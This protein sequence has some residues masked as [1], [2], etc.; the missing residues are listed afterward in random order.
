MKIEALTSFCG[1]LSMARGEVRD[2]NNEAVIADLLSAG[3]IKTVDEQT[4]SAEK[5]SKAST[6]KGVKADESQ[7]NQN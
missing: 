3:Y 2:Y 5:K 4:E 6:R 7:R 1:V